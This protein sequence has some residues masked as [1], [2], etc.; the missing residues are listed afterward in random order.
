VELANIKGEYYKCLSLLN[1]NNIT[2]WMGAWC[3]PIKYA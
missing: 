3:T 2:V 1:N